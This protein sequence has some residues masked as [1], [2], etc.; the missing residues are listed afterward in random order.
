[1]KKFT[2]PTKRRIKNYEENVDEGIC[3]AIIDKPSNKD[4]ISY[5]RLLNNY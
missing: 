3:Y 5:S 4:V 2:A 1:M